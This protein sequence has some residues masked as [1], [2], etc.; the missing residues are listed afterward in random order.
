MKKIMILMGSIFFI[1]LPAMDKPDSKKVKPK[2]H[3]FTAHSITKIDTDSCTTSAAIKKL[4]EITSAFQ[5]GTNFNCCIRFEQSDSS[6]WPEI[7]IGER[8]LPLE[9]VPLVKKYFD[10]AITRFLETNEYTGKLVNLIEIKKQKKRNKEE[11]LDFLDGL[12]PP[13]RRYL[14]QFNTFSPFLTFAKKVPLEIPKEGEAIK[15]SLVLNHWNPVKKVSFERYERSSSCKCKGKCVFELRGNNYETITK[16]WFEDKRTYYI[17]SEEGKQLSEI[18]NHYK[19]EPEYTIGFELHKNQYRFVDFKRDHKEFEEEVLCTGSLQDVIILNYF[20]WFRKRLHPNNLRGYLVLQIQDNMLHL[21]VKPGKVFWR[22]EREKNESCVSLRRRSIAFPE[23]I[24]AFYPSIS[25][26]SIVLQTTNNQ[27]LLLNIKNYFNFLHLFQL[28]GRD[29]KVRS[30][31]FKEPITAVAHDL[32]LL[33]VATGKKIIVY[34]VS[35]IDIKWK[36]SFIGHE[37]KINHLA[38]YGTAK[39]MS[40]SDDGTARVWDLFKKN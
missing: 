9:A 6:I 33:A 31:H 34:D 12:Y 26:K 22:Q 5:F 30:L 32:D 39:L 13:I 28:F 36:C 4:Q 15:Q 19:K 20:Q 38:F 18:E 16:K 17:W 21:S 24:K 2:P 40:G 1:S 3:F 35:D 27:L 11:P 37:E 23:T 25:L 14:V 7:K 29:F 8:V 10:E